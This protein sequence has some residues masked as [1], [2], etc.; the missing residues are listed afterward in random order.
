MVDKYG[1]ASK[2]IPLEAEAIDVLE[3]MRDEF[4]AT[5]GR[6][7]RGDDVVFPLTYMYSNEKFDRQMVSA[8]REAHI[9]PELIYA[10]LK[11]KR[12]VTERTKDLLSDTE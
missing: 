6:E 4:Q 5:F 3:K 1:D 8:M 10:Y 9:R 12:I 11:T 7:P 2:G